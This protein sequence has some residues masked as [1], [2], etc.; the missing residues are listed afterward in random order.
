VNRY[1]RKRALQSGKSLNQIIIEELSEKVAP[2][3]ATVDAALAWFIG[4]GMD[5]ATLQALDKEDKVQKKL[6]AKDL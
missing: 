3:T 4:G 6:A 1:L 5:D 2:P